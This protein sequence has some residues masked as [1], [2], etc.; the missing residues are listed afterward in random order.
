MTSGAPAAP[1]TTVAQ[2][3]LFYRDAYVYVTSTAAIS[4]ASIDATV[5]TGLTTAG[6]GT[7]MIPVP[8][9]HSYKVTSGGTITTQWVLL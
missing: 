3:N 9:G 1:G 6:A 4:S 2:A 7:I 5:I 8:A